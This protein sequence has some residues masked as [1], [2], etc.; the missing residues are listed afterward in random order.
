MFTLE[1]L[2]SDVLYR[3][4]VNG[5]IQPSSSIREDFRNVGEVWLR[6]VFHVHLVKIL[7]LRLE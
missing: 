3:L 6:G 7:D 4:D 5:K 2:D 1:G